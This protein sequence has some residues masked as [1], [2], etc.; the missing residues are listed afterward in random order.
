MTD[1]TVHRYG[2]DA[3]GRD[4][5]MTA[6]LHDWFERYVDELGWRPTVTQGAFMSRLGGGAVASEGAHDLG[7]CLDL[8]TQG[9]STAQI[10]HMVNTARRLG[11]GAYRRDRSARHGNMPP[12]MHL[13][14]GTDRPLSPMAQTLW[15]SYLGGGDGL[16]AGANRPANA[17]DYEWRP[18]PLVTVPPPMQEDDLMAFSDWSK[19]ER[20]AF[21]EF[22]QAQ[23][24]A[25]IIPD[26][27]QP[28][29]STADEHLG[30]LLRR[31]IADYY[32]KD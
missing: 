21:G 16:A 24:R 20:K 29:G 2:R 12:H 3:Y 4:V 28:D 19:D 13:T 17:P 25:T 26:A 7:G 1:Y 15:S 27:P 32:R 23:V 18:N 31:V 6:Y 30:S 9:R 14:L 11:A 5:L 10:D 8:E 22:I